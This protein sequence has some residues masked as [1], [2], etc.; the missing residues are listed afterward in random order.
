MTKSEIQEIFYEA[1][2]CEMIVM[3][4]KPGGLHDIENTDFSE[5]PEVVKEAM[6][7]L[8]EVEIDEHV[9]NQWGFFA[10]I[11]DPSESQFYIVTLGD[12]IYFVDNQGYDYCRYATRLINIQPQHA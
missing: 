7:K 10:D 9:Y 8:P 3:N 2:N 1:F 11:L 6:M 4:R 5:L 12:D